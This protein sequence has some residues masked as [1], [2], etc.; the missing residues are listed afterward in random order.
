MST[1]EKLREITIQ[2][3]IEQQARAKRTN[4]STPVAFLT[5]DKSTSDLKNLRV[6]QVIPLS[7]LE[8]SE[9]WSKLENMF[10]NRAK[11]GEKCAFVELWEYHGVDP[12]KW[13][14]FKVTD[15][16][17]IVYLNKYVG[18]LVCWQ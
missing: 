12:N 17:G 10:T 6:K 5:E 3:N 4:T 13:N 18:K 7:E 2:A 15:D 14:G 16:E 1:A 11:S 9:N 8:K